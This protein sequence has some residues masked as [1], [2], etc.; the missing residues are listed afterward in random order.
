MVNKFVAAANI[1]IFGK[2]KFDNFAA[3][4]LTIQWPRRKD[5]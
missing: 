1:Q 2:H 5:L 3:L 4:K